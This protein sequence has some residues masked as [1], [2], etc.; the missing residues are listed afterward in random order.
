MDYFRGVQ[1]KVYQLEIQSQFAPK[2]L[3]LCLVKIGSAKIT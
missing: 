3:A 2:P 1:N